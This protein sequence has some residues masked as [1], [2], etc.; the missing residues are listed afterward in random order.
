M[1]TRLYGEVDVKVVNVLLFLAAINQPREAM[2]VT[3]TA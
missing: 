3:E 2:L 1:G